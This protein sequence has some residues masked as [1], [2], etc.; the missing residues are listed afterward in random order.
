MKLLKKSKTPDPRPS[1]NV[2]ALADQLRRAL[3]AGVSAKALRT[4]IR[5][6]RDDC[7]LVQKRRASRGRARGGGQ[8]SKAKGRSA[9]ALVRDYLLRTY[10]LA[11]DDIHIKATSQGG[12]DL[13]LSPHAQ[14][15]FPFAIEVKSVEA[16]SIWGALA[17]AEANAKKKG[18]PPVLF[19]KRAHSPLYVAF[20]ASSLLNHLKETYVI[21][22]R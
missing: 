8:S 15:W 1:A 5:D 9:V 4:A 13:H 12:C 22:R 11:D 2:R 20:D 21:A 16:L 14:S 10:E 3:V 17:Q 18:A 7:A 19:F 6:L